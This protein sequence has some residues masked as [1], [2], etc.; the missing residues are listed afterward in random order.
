MFLPPGPKAIAV[1][2]AITIPKAITVPKKEEVKYILVEL[3]PDQKQVITLPPHYNS[4]YRNGEPTRTFMKSRDPA[5]IF[6]CIHCGCQNHNVA[7]EV[8]RD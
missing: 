3:E 6:M 8:I 5:A 2:K 4:D 1:P 7:K